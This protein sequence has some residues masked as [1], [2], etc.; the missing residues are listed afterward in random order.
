MKGK[1]DIFISYRRTAYDTANL[2]AVKLRHA[3]YRVFFDV[4]TLTAG[5]FNEQLLEVIKGCK[6]FILVLPENA[7]DRCVDEND[8]IRQEVTCAL[9]YRK[10]IIPV[11]LDGFAWPKE[12]PKGME[13]LSKYQAITAI[14]HE[15]FDM[16]VDRLKGYLKSSPAVPV[17]RWLLK[18]GIALAV[19][20]A[21][22]GVGCGVMRHIANVT[23]EEIATKQTNVMGAVEAIADMRQEMLEQST[24][25]FAAM[26]KSKD[27]EEQTE[28]ESELK[29]YLKKAEKDMQAYKKN[30]PAPDFNLQG[31]ENYVL[32]YYDVNQEELK[33]FST[34]Y[35]SLYDDLEGVAGTL[36][37]MV[38][39]HSY[40]M[41]Y[42]D[43]V[44]TSLSCMTYSINAFYY[45]YLGSLSL[46]PKDA[47]KLHYEMAKK[48]KH[49]PNG[50]P[51]DLSQEEY[52]QF[53]AYEMNQYQEELEKL[54]AQ[55]NYEER[56]LDELEKKIDQFQDVV[57]N[58]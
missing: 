38:E 17:K 10:N 16:A 24:S 52:E 3:G 55:V 31:V 19:L 23:C 49:F 14:N 30:Y 37:E 26:E 44:K 20:L 21:F 53:Q 29:V 22:V 41:E 1:Y 25:F 13:E 40:P 2:I 34:F 5:K 43:A 4:D 46:L 7:L 45:G 58:Q 15:Y 32:A 50:T 54:G 36:K 6:D 48:W 56:K 11:M 28:L 35:M 12:M 33:A 9:E 8:W 47:R 57:E 18:A 27:E 42:K 39:E 51:L